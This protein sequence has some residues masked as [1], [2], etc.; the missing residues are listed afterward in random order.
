MKVAIPVRPVSVAADAQ[1]SD[2]H[3]ESRAQP[4]QVQY[5][6]VVAQSV[7]SQRAVQ[8]ARQQQ[9]RPAFLPLPQRVRWQPQRV[10]VQPR[11]PP[12]QKHRATPP[13]LL[14]QQAQR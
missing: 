1:R 5:R 10:W 9:P 7:A 6:S 11:Q 8:V 2:A 14:H 12:S 3:A 4:L 13:K